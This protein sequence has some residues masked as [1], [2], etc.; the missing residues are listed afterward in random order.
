[1]NKFTILP[2]DNFIWNGKELLAFLIANQ[3]KDIELD[4]NEE[5]S[6]L[7][8]ISVYEMLDMFKFNSVSITTDNLVESHDRYTIIP[9]KRRYRFF[10]AKGADYSQY[11]T[12]NQD[13]IFGALYNRASWHR[14]GLATHLYKKRTTLNFRYDPHNEDQRSEFDL[15][16]L[17][18]IDPVSVERFMALYDKFPHQLE[19]VD[20]YTVGATTKTHT[21]QLADFYHDFLI[22]VVSESFV[23]GRTFYATEKTV[24][25]MLMKKPFIVMGPKCFLIHL[26]QMGFKTFHDFWDE[27]YDGYSPEIRYHR[28]LNLIDTLNEKS[29]DELQDMYQRMQPILDHNYN[30]L[31]TGAFSREI[32]YTE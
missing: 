13:T 30:L 9:G 26:R 24:R 10:D 14:I 17:F 8:S 6:C 27:D 1:M 19:V 21:E 32:V 11:H 3:D 16:Q 23:N 15:Q 29:F 18:E 5:G 28:I 12:W 20:G 25:P 2:E 4:I 7:T 31:T 22:D